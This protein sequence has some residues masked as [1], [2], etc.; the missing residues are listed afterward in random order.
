MDAASCEKSPSPQDPYRQPTQTFLS[1]NFPFEREL[2]RLPPQED[3]YGERDVV[4]VGAVV[5]GL[6]GLLGLLRLAGAAAAAAG[7]AAGDEGAAEAAGTALRTDPN[8]I[9]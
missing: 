8:G 2:P 5:V 4:V 9:T 1:A 7:G 6:L 3:L